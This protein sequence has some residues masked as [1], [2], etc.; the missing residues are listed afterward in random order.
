LINLLSHLAAILAPVFLTTLVGFGWVKRGYSFDQ[1]FATRV[2]GSLATPCLV[3]STLTRMHVSGQD[4]LTMG[5]A[6]FS[7]LIVFFVLGIAGLKLCRLSTSVFLPALAFP[8]NGNMGLPLCLFAFGDKGVAL[9]TIYFTVICVFQFTL[10][11][12]LSSGRFNLSLLLKAPVVY[13]TLAAVAVVVLHLPVPQW[14]LNTA[15]LMGQLCVPL[16]LLAL[17]VALAQLKVASISRAVN[18]SLLRF[19][20]GLASGVMVSMLF[21]FHGTERGVVILESAMP[22]AVFNYLF[23]LLYDNKP[24]EVAGVIMVSTI[25]SYVT[26]PF[27]IAM[28]I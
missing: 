11:P 3:F 14:L 26:L 5:A 28:V 22:A 8:N 19:G 4:F 2:I 24:E 18:V 15:G 6:A 7:C 13:A 1:G 23:A 16:M 27:L 10:G 20:V 9:A 17:G 25:L 21:G 12:L